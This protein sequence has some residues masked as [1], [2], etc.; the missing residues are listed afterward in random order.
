MVTVLIRTRGVSRARQENLDLKKVSRGD[1][2]KLALKL[3]AATVVAL[4][5]GTGSA[6][7]LIRS[8]GL[9]GD[10]AVGPWRTSTIIGSAEADPYTR[11]MVAVA[12]LLALNRSETIYFT[13]ARDGTGERLRTNCTYKVAGTDPPARW[14]S[15]TLYA[16]DHYLMPN[17]EDRYSYGGNTVAREDDGS[18]VIAV[19]P[20]KADGN[21][22]PTGDGQTDDTFTLTLRLYNP[23]EAA[24]RDPSGVVLPQIAKEACPS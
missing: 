11:A 12:G 7:L 1:H 4:I 24:A 19:G 8:G 10:V 22:I 23:E 21:W 17:P 18:F 2:L 3:L 13:A 6:L 14:W 15:I 16:S 5:L 20:E 9:G